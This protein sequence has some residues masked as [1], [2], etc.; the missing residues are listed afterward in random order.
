MEDDFQDEKWLDLYRTAILELEHAK[1]TGRIEDARLAIVL[2][3]EKLQTLPG[4][5]D[6]ERQAI[7]DALSGLRVLQ[8]E[9]DRYDADEKKR[10]LDRSL[11]ALKSVGPA[12]QRSA[13]REE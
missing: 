4:L 5:H 10:I 12:I 9:Q 13:L 8:H 3:V 1:I 11:Q 7:T 2:R 6:E